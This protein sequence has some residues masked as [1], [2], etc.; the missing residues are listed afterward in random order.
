LHRP[1]RRYTRG[2]IVESAFYIQVSNAILPSLL[3][4]C[5]P[6]RIITFRVFSHFARSQSFLNWCY[7][8]L[9]F[10]LSH[11]FSAAV[12]TLS[13]S[14]F[15]APILP[16]S[17]LIGLFGLSLSYVADRWLSLFVCQR[18]RSFNIEALDYVSV[19][20]TLLPFAQLLLTYLLYFRGEDLEGNTLAPFALGMGIYMLWLFLPIKQKLGYS[21]YEIMDDGGTGNQR[22]AQAGSFCEGHGGIRTSPPPL[23]CSV[24]LVS[25]PAL[26]L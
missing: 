14:I 21:R 20:I 11:R 10:H 19:L 17:P 22:C 3:T 1:S 7:T 26:L 4:V 24:L 16:V 13:L 5:N 6:S 15:Y 23:P 8:P 18:P 25:V 12:R 9:E 2:G